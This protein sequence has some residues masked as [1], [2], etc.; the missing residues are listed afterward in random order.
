MNELSLHPPGAA[1]KPPESDCRALVPAEGPV[2]VDTFG[3]RLHVEWDPSAAVT[4]LGQ[5]P[6]FTEFLKV[7]GLFDAWVEACPVSWRS[8]NAP[9][10]RDVLGTAVLAIL[11]GHWRYA[12]ISAL[13][14]DHV[15]AELLG[16]EK[17]ASEDSV[18]AT[19]ARM[20]EPT[21]LAWLRTHLLAVTEP[22]LGEPWILDADVTVK[23][24][25]GHQ[26]GA[27]LGY[28]PHKPGRPSHTYHTYFIANLRLVLDVEVQPGNQHHSKY[29]AP[30][31]WALLE[32]IG[33][34]RWP[35]LLRGDRDWGTEA[36]MRRCEQEGLP[37]LFKQ[38]LTKRTK[39]LVERLLRDAEWTDAGQGWQGA[40]ASLRL[41]G[42]SRSRRV[43]V[44]RRRLARDL[45]IEDRGESGQLRLSF[46]EVEENVRL[47]EYGVLVTSL[48]AEILTIAGLYR[49][50]A[51]CENN[52]DELKNHWGW[53]GFT[54][55]DL[56]RCRIMASMTALVYDWWSIFVRL[57]EP[58][59]HRESIT[60][61]PL[62]LN[63]PARRIDHAR[64]RRLL[65]SHQH[66][67]ADWVE[68]ACRNLAAFLHGLRLTA[69]QLTP[70]QRWYR[71]LSRAMRK[72]LHGRQLQPPEPLPAPP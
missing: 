63:A 59:K 62:L 36:N 41:S 13:R 7:S 40:E 6:F 38:R 14:G 58:D 11:C 44:L 42:W 27:V 12:H 54:T 25:Y 24:I 2:A 15:N 67:E 68:R 16:M 37:Y 35:R 5:L 26:E 50:R 30:G 9:N 17:V 65:I 70:T 53:G 71:I 52:F 32:Q 22:L 19:F 21:A 66:A 45:A 20:D 57:A 48:D 72:Y 51:D 46:T 39:Q 49:D 4:P 18:R 31:L 60:S 29:S 69:E 10:K 28:N 34:A 8:N 55:T 3:G 47:Y 56:K 23:P 43:V 64:Q 61:R 1:P 33:R